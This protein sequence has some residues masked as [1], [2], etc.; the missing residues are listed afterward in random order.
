MSQ[1]TE[2]LLKIRQQ[3]GEQLT[4]LQGSLKNLGQQSSATNVNFKELSTELKNIQ[5][6]S[7]QSI[8]NLRGYAT[9]WREIANSVKIGTAEFKQA[10]AEAA[11]LEAQLEKTQGKRGRLAAGAQIAGTIAGAGV[12]GAVL[13][14]GLLANPSATTLF[15][16]L[17]Q[18]APSM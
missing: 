2:L 14:V 8:N 5:Q 18:V 3:G 1:T 9:A 4:R 10:S 7:V 11:K 6:T 12:F 15:A 13:G 16:G 17:V